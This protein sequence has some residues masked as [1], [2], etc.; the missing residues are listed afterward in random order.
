MAQLLMGQL[1]IYGL[2]WAVGWVIIREERGPIALWSFR[3]LLQALALTMMADPVPGGPPVPVPAGMV[4]LLSYTCAAVGIDM[5]AHQGR[6]R[7]LNLW[8]VL[9]VSGVAVQA[10]SLVWPM[11]VHLRVAAYNLSVAATLV[12]PMLVLRKPLDEEFGLW[13]LVPMVPGTLLC[14]LSVARAAAVLARPETAL[15]APLL[16]PSNPMLLLA[17]LLAAGAFNVAFLAL[18]VGRLIKRMNGLID[19]DALTHLVNRGGLE[20][21]LAAAWAASVRHGTPLSVAFIDL[22]DFKLV[23]DL[24]SHE[25]GDQVLQGVAKALQRGARETDH[26]GRW[27]GDEFMVVMPHTDAE[28][29]RQAMQR[30]RERVRDAGIV[31]PPGCQP[32]SLSIG[33]ATRGAEDRST[34]SLVMRADAAMYGGKRGRS[35]GS[36]AP[37]PT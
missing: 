28:A 37:E 35:L 4:L 32:L 29:A 3:S 33:L 36:A 18:V 16:T 11:P 30:L 10:G 12:A 22:D 27:G 15:V 24:G 14:A 21:R 9:L 20:R 17:T 7:Y 6:A 25:F 2:A 19:T 13:G 5:F 1:L 26:V 23:N 8:L 31:L 34:L